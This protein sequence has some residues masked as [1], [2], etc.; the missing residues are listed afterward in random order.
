MSYSPLL[1]QL[2]QDLPALQLPLIDY[3]AIMPEL[4]LIGLALV[5]M[6]GAALTRRRLPRGT[7]AVFTV[8]ASGASMGYAYLLWNHVA[9]GGYTAI[10]GSVAVDGFSVFFM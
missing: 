10:A 8:A 1:A 4:I 2:H 7:Y 9:R 3:S 5:L 6:T